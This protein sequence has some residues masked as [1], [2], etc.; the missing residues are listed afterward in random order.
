MKQSDC[1]ICRAELNNGLC[2]GCGYD[3][4]GDFLINRTLVPVSE[5]SALE[6]GFCYARKA[7]RS[8]AEM[9]ELFSAC[10]NTELFPR[11][12]EDPK[13]M[14]ASGKAGADLAWTLNAAG[15][16]TISG[17]GSMDDYNLYSPVQR[18]PPPWYSERNAIRRVEILLA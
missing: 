9:S 8:G 15:T 10:V 16:L 2:C 11:K 12:K 13:K 1:P 7:M 6:R 18:M 3:E 5:L 4:S 14:V 17:T